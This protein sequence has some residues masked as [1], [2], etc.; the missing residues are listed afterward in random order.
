MDQTQ[1]GRKREDIM[2]E[3]INTKEL[4]IKEVLEE[5]IDITHI[6]TQQG[7]CMHLKIP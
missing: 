5:L 1:Y 7:N 6:L 2:K 3:E 4:V